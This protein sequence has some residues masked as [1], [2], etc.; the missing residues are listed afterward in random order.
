MTYQ[1]PQKGLELKENCFEMLINVATAH[2][3]TIKTATNK[4]N[5]VLVILD[6]SRQVI[7]HDRASFIGYFG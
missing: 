1:I 5:E 4:H 7:D 3:K 6:K 2:Q